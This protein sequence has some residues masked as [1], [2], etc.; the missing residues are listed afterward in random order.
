MLAPP[1]VVQVLLSAGGVD[2]RGLEMAQGVLAD[3]HLL[4]GGRDGQT[5][6]TLKCFAV[7]Y[8]LTVVGEKAE[9]PPASPSP[10]A[11]A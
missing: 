8:A 7:R 10:Q 1:G 5:P 2:S 6:H 4:P 11:R 3:P 9:A